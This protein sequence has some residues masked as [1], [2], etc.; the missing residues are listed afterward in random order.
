MV[1]SFFVPVFLVIKNVTL[2]LEVL[3]YELFIYINSLD[4]VFCKEV[5]ATRDA[6]VEA[7]FEALENTKK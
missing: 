2:L 4:N 6:V 3:Y 5:Y 1:T 7:A